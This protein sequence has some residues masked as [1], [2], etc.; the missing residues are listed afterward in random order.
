MKM[1][2]LIALIFTVYVANIGLSKKILKKVNKAIVTT[3]EV[4]EFS[5]EPIVIND[6]VNEQLKRK[7][8]DNSLF[9]IQSEN[10]LIGY[11]YLGK[12]PSKTAT[13]DFLIL[14]DKDLI[15]T[16]TK[17]LIYR[18]EYGG[19]IGS[20]RWLKQFI[21]SSKDDIY[22]PNDNIVAI[23][24]ATISVNS[25]TNAVNEVLQDIGKLQSLDIF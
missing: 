15:V 7:I 1:K 14:F 11:A 20:K 19:E 9:E 5:L 21:G 3:Y 17:V 13:F 24:G 22:K 12:A 10:K 2:L 6:N 16:K 25:M 4:E 18:E 8:N 23:A